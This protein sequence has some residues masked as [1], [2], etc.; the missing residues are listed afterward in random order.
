MG[1]LFMSGED[2]ETDE[3]IGTIAVG[4]LEALKPGL[5][6]LVS[7]LVTYVRFDHVTMEVT[8]VKV[9]KEKWLGGRPSSGGLSCG[10]TEPKPRNSGICSVHWGTFRGKGEMECLSFFGEVILGH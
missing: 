7:F 5:L 9:R 3:S 10:S 2:A 1:K 4:P 8:V 6:Q